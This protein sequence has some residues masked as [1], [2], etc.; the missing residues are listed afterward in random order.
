MKRWLARLSFSF[1]I[2]AIVL[3][4]TGYQATIDNRGDVPTW[5]IGAEFV[6]AVVLFVLG[7]IGVRER[8]RP[9]E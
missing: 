1:F 2:I 6:V 5:K 3:A 7:G 4:W 9:E 8:H